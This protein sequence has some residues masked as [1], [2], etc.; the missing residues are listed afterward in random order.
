MNDT[1]DTLR[2]LSDALVHAVEAAAPH[3]VRVE[4]RRRGH[5]SGI[6]WSADGLIVTA[7]HTV[8]RDDDLRVGLPSGAVVHAELVGRD[9]SIDI[10]V[11]KADAPDLPTPSWAEDPPSVGHLVLSVGRHDEPAQASLGIVS[12]TGGPWRTQLGGTI[13]A[14]VQTDIGVYPGFSGSALVGAEGQFFGMNTSW[15][16]R[17]SS[18]LLPVAT[19]RSAAEAILEHGRIRRGYL[20]V[21]AHPAALPQAATDEL[22]RDAG[23][24]VLSIEPG[25]PAQTADLLVGD[26]IVALD[27]EPTPYMDDL[28][29]LLSG[30]RVG[31]E[32]PVQVVRGGQLTALA[33]TLQERS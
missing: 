1:T 11:L 6:V 17:R 28:M 12:K 18:M 19:L 21:Q 24:L 30:D 33:V 5:S 26:I 10:A 9:P 25:S 14:Y 29:A 20:G 15:F 22:G 4:A 32:V 13:D 31:R 23:L 8:Q 2:A 16:R 7:H 27:G 3:I